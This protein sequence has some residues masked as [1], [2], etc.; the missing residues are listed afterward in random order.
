LATISWLSSETSDS[1]SLASR[2]RWKVEHRFQIPR[3]GADPHLAFARIRRQAQQRNVI[4]RHGFEHGEQAFPRPAQLLGH[5]AHFGQV[6]PP[7]RGFA[8]GLRLELAARFRRS[9]RRWA[10][11]RVTLL[12]LG[13]RVEVLLHAETQQRQQHTAAEQTPA[14]RAGTR[15]WLKIQIERAHVRPPPGT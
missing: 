13:M 2:R 5:L 11:C 8:A 14:Q 9:V 10:V 3:F 7:V 1:S 6:L 15:P 12:L 4:T